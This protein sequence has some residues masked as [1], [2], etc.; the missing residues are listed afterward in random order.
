MDAKL[1]IGIDI[2]ST[3]VKLSVADCEEARVIEDCYV[4]H[5]ARQAAT[6]RERLG[7]PRSPETMVAFGCAL[8]GR[9]L[10]AGKSEPL[11]IGEVLERLDRAE[12]A[13]NLADA[14]SAE[15]FFRTAREREAFERRHGAE[16]LPFA[17]PEAE[18]GELPVYIGIDSGSTTSKIVLLDR[19]E[20][21]IDS[22]YAGN[23][24]CSSGCGSFLENFAGSLGMEAGDIAEAA[25]SSASPAKLGS[26]CTVFMN[27]TIIT[28]QRRGK[29]PADIMAG[30]CRSI[31]E[32]VFT[33]VVRVADPS[34]L[35]SK[36]V[37]Q[38]GTF[39]NRAV[40]RAMEEY[41]GREVF[42]A[43]Y[44][45]EMGAI[46]AALLA[47]RERAE[48]GIG[49]S[50]FKGFEA[51]SAL[52]WQTETGAV[53]EGL[54]LLAA[55][56]YDRS[57]PKPRVFVTG[58][59]LVTY[60]EG[61][62]FHIEKYLENNGMETI[63]PRITDQLRKDFLASSDEIREFKADIPRYPI[64]ITKLFDFIQD[65]LEKQALKHPLF[66]RGLKPA[67]AY[68]GV[69]DI[70]P[71]SLS[72]GEGWLMAAEINHYAEQGVRAAVI[73]Q[74]FGCLPNH[75]CGRGVIKSLKDR[76]PGIMILP[77]DLDPDTSYANVENRLQ[78]LIMNQCEIVN[79]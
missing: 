75:V 50:R 30:L 13:M 14:G 37:V 69:S 9:K 77:L 78:M 40:L 47:A 66:E 70:I 28:E 4:R 55:V 36:V 39:R 16:Q 76:H 24:A 33:K 3:T 19:S 27:S 54:A 22:F 21:V 31:I 23:E 7:L 1:S 43:P 38:G 12:A 25:F 46:G 53:C 51:L 62:N 34:K 45:G 63:F 79:N 56:P 52:T 67:E 2:G 11:T 72:C 5:H 18:D 29:S 20:R 44:P 58:E 71:M 42:L 26:R 15:P 10:F 48:K 61:S 65:K 73:L 64:L 8:A 35:G 41:L 32:N 74:P 49:E 59:L 17:R 60:H 6:L 57:E 68:R